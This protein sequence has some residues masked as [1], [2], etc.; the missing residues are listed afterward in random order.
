MHICSFYL[1]VF[2]N[3]HGTSNK[4]SLQLIKTPYA[5]ACCTVLGLISKLISAP[6]WRL[7]ENNVHVLDLNTNYHALVSYLDKMSKYAISCNDSLLLVPW[8]FSKT[9]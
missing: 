4:L 9:S 6:L 2:E 3:V 7:I 5:I 1:D 8:T